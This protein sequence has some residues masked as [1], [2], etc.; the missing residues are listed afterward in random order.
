MRT[1][2]LIARIMKELRSPSNNDRLAR[3]MF[4]ANAVGYHVPLNLSVT[5]Q[6]CA[7]AHMSFFRGICGS[8]NENLSLDTKKAQDVFREIIRIRY[9]L[10]NGVIDPA[11]V[12]A[13]LCSSSAQDGLTREEFSMSEWLASR[14]DFIRC[15]LEIADVLKQTSEA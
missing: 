14:P 2:F 6:E 15:Q 9:E 4:V 10:V 12:Q 5:A 11:I 1:G 13:A 8:V 7:D 3:A